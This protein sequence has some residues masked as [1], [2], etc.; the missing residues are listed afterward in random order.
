MPATVSILCH[1]WSHKGS[2]QPVSVASL[3]CDVIISDRLSFS[4]LPAPCELQQF[5]ETLTRTAAAATSAAA[6]A[7]VVA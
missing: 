3:T 2:G 4:A 1:S 6:V 5:A 7:V